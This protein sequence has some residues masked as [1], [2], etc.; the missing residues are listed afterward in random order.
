[1]TREARSR[2]SVTGVP[3]KGSGRALAAAGCVAV[4]AVVFLLLSVADGNSVREPAEDL[5]NG[6][7]R[8]PLVEARP[9]SPV[10]PEKPPVEQLDATLRHAA[11]P[12]ASH[13]AVGI[14]A[15]QSMAE[16]LRWLARQGL[17]VPPGLLLDSPEA[18]EE[19]YRTADG[20]RRD[21]REARDKVLEMGQQIAEERMSKGQFEHFQSDS[22]VDSEDPKA[23]EKWPWMF[24]KGMAFRRVRHGFEDGKHVAKV[25]DVMP[26]ESAP[27][28][29]ENERA[30]RCLETMRA[31][32][33]DLI[34]R[35]RVPPR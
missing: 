13:A 26:G 4:L 11:A 34:A 31:A 35:R 20:A 27:L 33:R 16:M 29:A 5:V 8:P 9:R 24:R 15:P 14:G 17:D 21:A 22:K 3:S 10:D 30:E 2:L 32:I 7:V 18:W 12:E 6:T 1:M 19:L 28:D 23:Q 25:V